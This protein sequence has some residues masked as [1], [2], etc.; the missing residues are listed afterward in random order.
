M[1][2]EP[3]VQSEHHVHGSQTDAPILI[4]C[5][6]GPHGRHAEEP[7]AEANVLT[8]HGTHMSPDEPE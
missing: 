7:T 1:A 5:V 4:V 8:G 6:D 2:Y 3:A